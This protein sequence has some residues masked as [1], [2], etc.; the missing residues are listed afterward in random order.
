MTKKSS[1]TENLTA[2]EGG[3]TSTTQVERREL[4]S[5]SAIDAMGRRFAL[6]AEKHGMNNWRKGGAQ[7]RLSRISHLIEH[8]YDYLEH[9]GRENI[10]A[11]IC[12]A[13]MLCEFEEKDPYQGVVLT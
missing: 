8:I 12:N 11:I 3:A 1:K 9:G 5:K 13:A 6:G 4:I 2:F 7:F 10:D